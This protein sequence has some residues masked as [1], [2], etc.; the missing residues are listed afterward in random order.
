MSARVSTGV[1][2]PRNVI[3]QPCSRNASPKIRSPRSCRSS[4]G[5]A[6]TARGPLP[7]SHPRASPSRRPRMRCDAK[8][9]CATDTSP[10]SQPSPSSRKSG[11][12]APT[13]TASSEKSAR[14]R[15]KAACDAASSNRWIASLSSTD[16]PSAATSAVHRLRQRLARGLGGRDARC[17]QL[18]H[19]S[20]PANVRARVE[21]IAALGPRR[22]EQAV[23]ALPRAQQVGRDS[24]APRELTDAE[25]RGLAHRDSVQSLDK[26]LTSRIFGLYIPW[27]NPEQ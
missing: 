26:D 17:E 23:A 3:R 2:P 19:P 4:G 11:S 1:S 14:R 25:F 15:S 27:T 9:S 18:A 7:R 24:G 22:G 16:T 5:Q 13:S 10:L 8:C 21:P 20:D 6:S 12:T